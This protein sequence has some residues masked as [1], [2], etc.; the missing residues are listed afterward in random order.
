M[1]KILTI[2]LEYDLGDRK[3]HISRLEDGGFEK[4]VTAATKALKDAL[5][6]DGVSSVRKHMN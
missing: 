4:A 3:H 2:T 6:E 5:L 1:R